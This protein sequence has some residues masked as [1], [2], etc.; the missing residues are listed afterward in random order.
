MRILVILPRIP[1]PARDGGA[2]VM[3][4]TVR[5]LLERGHHVD[6]I[7]LNTRKHHADPAVMK[8]VCSS[9]TAVDVDTS[10]RPLRMAWTLISSA[11]PSEFG[12]PVGGSYWL[13]R[14]ASIAVLENVEEHL[15][16]HDPYDV[17]VCESLFTACYGEALRRRGTLA[18]H[19]PIVLHAHNVEG[20]IQERLSHDRRRSMIERFIRRRLAQQTLRYEHNVL[21]WCDA[22]LPLSD[23]D[24]AMF[25]DMQPTVQAITV[26]PGVQEHHVSTER[27]PNTLWFL[28]SLDWTPNV[29]GLHWFMGHVWPLIQ[30]RVPRAV[31]HIAGRATPSDVT[32]YHDGRCVVVHGEIDDPV[33]YRARYEVGIVPLLSGSGVRIKIIEALMDGAAIV[34]TSVGCEGLPLKTNEH[35]IIADDPKAFADACL[36][37]LMNTTMRESLRD[38]GAD[39]MRQQYSWEQSARRME[40]VLQNIVEKS[41]QASLSA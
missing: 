40:Q 31:M 28:G 11:F 38:H 39:V 33:V 9:I 8:G 36:E 13:T 21:S 19:I 37:L 32:A 6:V 4:E 30:A 14:F 7:A 1:M 27:E 29:D 16:V 24:R 17:I 5:S 2:I 23:V 25:E 12:I 35:V 3:L 10:I 41:R 34:T 15:R 18:A 22:V 26:A 20:R